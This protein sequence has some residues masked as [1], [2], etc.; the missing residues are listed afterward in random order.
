[1]RAGIVK[2]F[3]GY[4][5]MGHFLIL[6]AVYL[7]LFIIYVPTASALDVAVI[8][9]SAIKPYEDAIKGFESSCN[10]NIKRVIPLD[11]NGFSIEEIK[12]SRPGMVV[13]VGQEALTTALAFRDIPVLYMMVLNPSAI[14][15]GHDNVFGVSMEIPAARQI[16]SFV[17]VFP[18]VKRLGVIYNPANK[19]VFM[20]DA[21]QSAKRR[22]VVLVE[23]KV[24]SPKEVPSVLQSIRD[25]ID[26][27]WIL[28]DVTVVTPENTEFI[29]LYSIESNIPVITFTD[30]HVALGAVMSL[31][32]DPYEI[33]RQAG[34]IITSGSGHIKKQIYEASIA[35]V[36]INQITALKMA[37]A[38]NERFKN[39]GFAKIAMDV[40]E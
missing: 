9:S 28:P 30:R 20:K 31:N 2:Y 11:S 17:D 37:I 13:A 29:M 24:Q 26:A 33:G 39:S 15:Q 16:A 27:L 21:A 10:C 4:S 18:W 6:V 40:Y 19:D 1:M 38:V 32:I 14:I 34:D 3:A 7:M 25:K 22:G 8:E 5:A 36:S 35:R 12:R 23:K